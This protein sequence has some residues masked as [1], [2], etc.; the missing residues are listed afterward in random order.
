MDESSDK[1]GAKIREA[2]L[3]KVP[4]TVVIG[5]KEVESKGV[6]PRVHGEGKAA[7]LG[8]LALDAFADRLVAEAAVPF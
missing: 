7:E 8:F 1:L 5:D 4:Y 2:Q 6:S 3:A